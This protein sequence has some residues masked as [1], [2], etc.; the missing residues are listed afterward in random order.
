MN[1]SIIGA[2]GYSGLELIRLIDQH[3]RF[4]IASV[5]SSSKADQPVAAENPHLSHLNFVYEP[6]EPKEIANK[7]KMVF[8]ATPSGISAALTPQLVS[9]GLKVIDLSGDLRLKDKQQYRDWYGKEPAPENLLSEAV[10]GLS[11]WNA[12]PIQHANVI[13]NPGCYP[14]A[15]LLGLAPLSTRGLCRSDQLIIDAKSGV[16][17]A[18]RSAAAGTMYSEINE[19]LKIYK[20]HTHQHIP[21]IEQQLSFWDAATG[22][23][24][25]NTHLIPMT[26]GI[27]VT[28]YVELKERISQ[29]DIH[30]LYEDD[31]RE[32]PFVRMMPL[33]SYPAT[34]QVLGS[35]FCD[36]GT[37]VNARTGR[38]TVVSVIDNLLK[39]AAGQA[40]Q[41][42][43]ILCGYEEAE[44]LLSIPQFP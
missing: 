12:E 2:S 33:G 23:I 31:Y 15:V 14:T 16:S 17:G 32:H 25:F 44:G 5:H 1:V 27:M 8:L 38:V 18:G 37:S 3:P 4:E 30:Q 9:E 20:V 28:M 36:I 21:E 43:N 42:A 34:K 22:S 13:A 19:N 26:R 40:I 41:N 39:G 35:N 11:E 6:I 24:E 29:E 10:Y 7:C